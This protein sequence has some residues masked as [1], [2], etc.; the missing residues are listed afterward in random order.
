MCHLALRIPAEVDQGPL[1]TI[2]A[3]IA[4]LPKEVEVQKE[5][6]EI[7]D[8]AYC[9]FNDK[10]FYTHVEFHC[11]LVFHKAHFYENA[12]ATFEICEFHKA[13]DFSYT[14]FDADLHCRQTF[15]HENADFSYI[16]CGEKSLVDFYHAVFEKE[17]YFS[18]S[19]FNQKA[20]FENETEFKGSA[21]FDHCIFIEVIFDKTRFRHNV[22][23]RNASFKKR[24]NMLSPFFKEE[25]A[26]LQVSTM[27]VNLQVPTENVEISF[28]SAQFQGISEYRDINFNRSTNFRN[29]G[30][31]EN[32]RTDFIHVT[33]MDEVDFSN[34]HSTTGSLIIFSN[35]SKFIKNSKFRYAAFGNEVRFEETMFEDQI[36]LSYSKFE[37]AIFRTVEFKQ[38]VFQ[39]AYFIRAIFEDAKFKDNANFKHAMF[40]EAI[41]TG[42]L[43]DK[44]IDFRFV[45]FEDGNNVHFDND[46]LRHVSF[47]N[48]DV[49]RIHFNENV[50]WNA[51]NK[52]K[53]LD[54]RN[55]FKVL[56]ERNLE[57][58]LEYMN[59]ITCLF[60]EGKLD[61]DKSESQD[62]YYNATVLHIK[63]E[64]QDDFKA[65]V[66]NR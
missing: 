49:S 34:A 5:V 61:L 28:E 3:S 1:K 53:V 27:N 12:L 40:K 26:E 59:L 66:S 9:S 22:T 30:F 48:T 14:S 16:K 25:H 55:K 52:F 24:M 15:F 65:N 31:D 4:K 62:F 33:F 13:A 58:Y 23:F 42:G 38:V 17:C 41:F 8:F 63:I 19:I 51:N 45:T 21:Y 39:G 36:D 20:F 56:D 18:N 37:E 10:V 64:K 50:S 60:N 2:Q 57:K 43:F 32:S 44:E 54:E 6:E 46:D 11:K 47:M 29:T 35:K 7:A